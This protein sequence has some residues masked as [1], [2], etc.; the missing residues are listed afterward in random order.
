MPPVYAIVDAG[1]AARH[2]W[3]VPDLAAAYLDG[4]ARLVQ[5]R[6]Q[7]VASGVL[8]GWCDAVVARASRYGAA[9]LV[10]DRADIARLCGA[11]GVH[12]GQEDL[13]VEDARNV[14]GESAIVGLSTHTVGQ[15]RNALASPVTYVAVG[16]VH[17]TGTKDTGYP[18]VGLSLVREAAVLAAATPVVAIG[19]ITLKG[20]PE[21]LAAGA[22][23][24]AVIG[25]LLSGGTPA[26]RVRTYVDRLAK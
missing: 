21:V 10:N 6:A 1:L 5:L 17:A 8:E 12:L 14:L 13:P 19:G 24:V 9:I 7:G 22:A 3:T 15:L 23:S 18:P 16:P 2:G 25:D 4:G 20:A 26:A 11:A